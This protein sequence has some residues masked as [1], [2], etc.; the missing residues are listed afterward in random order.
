M[1]YM[2][3]KYTVLCKTLQMKYKRYR[4]DLIDIAYYGKTN[5]EIGSDP[6][7]YVTVET[8]I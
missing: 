6:W 3:E 4:G 7:S 1:M 8:I 2:Y 5:E